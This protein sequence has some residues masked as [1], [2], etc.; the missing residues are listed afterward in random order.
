VPPT[1]EQSSVSGVRN[2][3][4]MRLSTFVI[5][6]A[7]S[8]LWKAFGSV[9]GGL[10]KEATQNLILH[11]FN[12]EVTL[13]EGNVVLPPH[14]FKEWLGTH[15]VLE[16]T[17]IQH[18]KVLKNASQTEA[19]LVEAARLAEL[20][21]INSYSYKFEGEGSGVTAFVLLAESH[22][23]LHSWPEHSF[24]SIDIFTCS[25]AWKAKVAA[26]YLQDKLE[27][28]VFVPASLPR[29][30]P[31]KTA[32]LQDMR[33]PS[34]TVQD[35]EYRK[36]WS[37]LDEFEQKK[38]PSLDEKWASELTDADLDTLFSGMDDVQWETL[39]KRKTE[40]QELEIMR[41]K[42]TDDV[43][44]VIDGT[45]QIC[46]SYNSYYS[47]VYVHLPVAFLHQYKTA[48]IIGGGDA[49]ALREVLKYKSI[50]RVVQLELDIEVPRIC[51]RYLG[52]NA[53]LPEN[54]NADKRVEWIFGDAAK[55]IKQLVSN[56]ER[57]DVVMLDISETDPSGTVSTVDFFRSVSGALHPWG[58]FVK[59]EDYQE[60]TAQLFNEYLE[61]S[62]PVPMITN[63]VFVL[64]SNLTSLLFPNFRLLKENN[65][66]ASFLA[67]APAAATQQLQSMIR[68]YSKKLDYDGVATDAFI[69][70]KN[71]APWYEPA[72]TDNDEQCSAQRRGPRL[73]EEEVENRK[74]TLPCFLE[75]QYDP[76]QLPQSEWRTD[77]TVKPSGKR[78]RITF[79]NKS[80][81]PV[82]LSWVEPDS[83]EEVTVVEKLMP[84]K[85]QRINTF[86]GHEFKVQDSDS[87]QAN[88]ASFEIFAQL[89]THR[90]ISFG[91]LHDGIAAARSWKHSL[92]KPREHLP[93][94]P[95]FASDA[96]EAAKQEE[97]QNQAE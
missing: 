65:V 47:E 52:I 61:V 69:D 1:K 37:D 76:D 8:I 64:G 90:F 78:M 80:P 41:S 35:I 86:I 28:A 77:C 6:F 74:E 71:R 48:L 9:D 91:G 32:F 66:K 97:N 54:P 93:P 4:T 95:S 83:N 68:R 25:A 22:I 57:F 12:E 53:H 46:E 2:L 58:I 39:E 49:L 18:T 55:T 72:P 33:F 45:I 13:R 59:N 89:L 88:I 62:Y 75:A 60:P 24:A 27:A 73:S 92:Q 42:E 63:Q 15:L 26:G 87:H 56:G 38:A 14:E 85:G 23:A 36:I 40:W 43:C 81:Q 29:G 79:I 7:A 3:E 51:E 20:T 84:G 96:E 67:T 50:E 44:L 11:D 70:K 17:E 34:A 30:V 31:A 5:S 82:A 16:F 21:V 10:S 94:R 19:M